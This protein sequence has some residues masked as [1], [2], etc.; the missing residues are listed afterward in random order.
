MTLLHTIFLILLSVTFVIAFS[1]K[2][3]VAQ[4]NSASAAPTQSSGVNWDKAV[5]LNDG[6]TFVSDGRLLLDAAMAKPAVLPTNVLPEVT[7]KRV[8]GYLTAALPDEF[9]FSQLTR[10]GSSGNY[11]APSGVVLNAIY[12]D[13]VR[14]TLPVSR[15]RFRMKSDFEPVVIL[16][17]GKA[18]GLLMP[19]RR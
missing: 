5:R 6:R 2:R 16:L 17:D 19:M 1:V 4:A 13:Y 3:A 10:D 18:V 14:R 8:E 15:L 11:K 7:A 9:G 12:I